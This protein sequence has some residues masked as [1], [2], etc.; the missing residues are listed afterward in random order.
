MNMTI[1]RFG[2]ATT[3]LLLGLCFGCTNMSELIEDESAGLNGGFEVTESGIPVNWLVYTPST[4]PSGDYD[5]IIDVEDPRSG[6]QSLKFVV[7]ECSSGGGWH[8][9]GFSRQFDAT[10]G[11]TYKVGLWVENDGAEFQARVGGVSATEGEYEIIVRSRETI[12]E[13]RHYEYEYA[14]PAEYDQLRFELNVLRP[15]TFRVD[16]VTIE[17]LD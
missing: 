12:A 2:H 7:R 8:S 17:G 1:R 3:A 10:P 11:A 15:G 5:L 13:W 4:I 14:M 16:D 6:S 9:P